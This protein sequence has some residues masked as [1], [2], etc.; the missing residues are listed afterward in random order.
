MLRVLFLGLPALLFVL[1]A[2]LALR[3]VPPNRYYGFRTSTTFS[4][5]VAWYQ[6]NLA[7]GIALIS[8]GVVAGLLTVWLSYGMIALKAE[9]RY[10][11]GILLT[12]IV[13][14]ASLIPVVIYSNRF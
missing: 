14:T 2:P 9:Q 13:M 6:I 7:T 1:G 3:L 8:A 4:S 12:A 11:L 5:Q 10:I